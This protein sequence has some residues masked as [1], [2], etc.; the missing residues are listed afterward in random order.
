[1]PVLVVSKIG[2]C[3]I[4]I[5][6]ARMSVWKKEKVISSHIL[7]L[8]MASTVYHLC[9][10]RRRYDTR[11]WWDPRAESTTESIQIS[12]RRFLPGSL[13]RYRRREWPIRLLSE[14][15][16]HTPALSEMTFELARLPD[17]ERSRRSHHDAARAGYPRS[18]TR[19]H[20]PAA[21]RCGSTED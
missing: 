10:R 4:W 3:I 12:S 1:M 19:R 17:S 8:S 2:K 14:I 21:G 6:V 15:G 18:P 20:M 16:L 5:S 9:Y 7:F 11:C 13:S